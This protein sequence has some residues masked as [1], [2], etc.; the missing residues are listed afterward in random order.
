MELLLVVE[1][2]VVLEQLLSDNI[3][4]FRQVLHSRFEMS[5]LVIFCRLPLLRALLF[6]SF[7]LIWY[8]HVAVANELML[9]P[10]LSV[11]PFLFHLRNLLLQCFG[12]LLEPFCLGCLLCQILERFVEPLLQGLP[13]LGRDDPLHS[14]LDL[15]EAN[16]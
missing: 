3:I 14:C 4:I 13:L 15:L 1:P 5:N 7:L 12:L 6:G 11:L 16:L 10:D 9:H 8:C 2:V